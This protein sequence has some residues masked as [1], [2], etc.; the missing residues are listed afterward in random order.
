MAKR[1]TKTTAKKTTAKKTASKPK[2]ASKPTAKKSPGKKTTAKKV[3]AAKKT[4]K[5]KT[6]TAKKVAPKKTTTAKK[7]AARK[8]TAKKVAPAKK[9]T[10]KKTT[11]QK[12]VQTAKA[13]DNKAPKTT[14]KKKT[15]AKKVA[16]TKSA[17]DKTPKTQTTPSK[18]KDSNKPRFRSP[19]AGEP[20]TSRAAAARLADLAGITSIRASE[21]ASIEAHKSYK[22]ITKSPLTTA[23]LK[24]FRELLIEKRRQLVGD[25]TSMEREALGGNSGSLSRLSQHMADQGSDVFDQTLNLDLA[26]SQRRFLTE[27]DDAIDRIDNGTY[28]ICEL[29]GKPIGLER[30]RN[31]PWARFSIEAARQIELNPALARTPQA[32]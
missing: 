30:L 17:D 5:K 21:V 18:S 7:V 27:I 13:A 11:T 25:V 14:T 12:K 26:A 10:A 16:S 2:P 19:F 32:E 23:Q 31:T 6:P 3:A 22:R 29:L 24:E 4:T 20:Q 9:T 8:T 1:T 15:T 28:G